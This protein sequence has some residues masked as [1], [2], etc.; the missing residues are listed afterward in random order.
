LCFSDVSC[1]W[2]LL[3]L[4]L[5]MMMMLLLRM[6]LLLV[7]AGYGGAAAVAAAG[8]IASVACLW[9]FSPVATAVSIVTAGVF[10]T[11]IADAVN[12]ADFFCCYRP[13]CCRHFCCLC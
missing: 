7:S 2:R 3:L 1:A 4:L 6:L 12:V 11:A 13:C 9:L 10:V 8:M 5:L